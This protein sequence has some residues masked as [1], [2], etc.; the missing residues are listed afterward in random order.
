VAI[1]EGS[2][3]E[4]FLDEIL[5]VEGYEGEAEKTVVA[6]M[7]V[8]YQ[9]LIEGNVEM[10]LLPEPL[11]TKAIAE[12][13]HL[14]AYDGE[15]NTTATVIV[16]NESF[17]SANGEKVSSFLDAYGEAVQLITSAPEEYMD[18]LVENARFPPELVD[19]Y[20]LQPLSMPSLPTG[21]EIARLQQWMMD[22]DLLEEE[23][24]YADLVSEELYD[25]T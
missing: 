20:E 3:I 6:S 10:A 14:I 19:N 12:G 25:Q 23:I 18:L 4:Y 11:A 24:P 15:V 16:M 17:V 1:S 21:S 9:Y 2:V 7:P 8:R 22:N 5:E 13:A